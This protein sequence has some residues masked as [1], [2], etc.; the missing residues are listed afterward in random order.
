MRLRLAAAVLAGAVAVA[1]PP[2][3]GQA[4]LERGETVPLPQQPATVW[5]LNV[6]ALAGLRPDYEG[7]DDYSFLGAP[8][9][10]LRYGGDRFFVS[11]RDGIGATL[12]R[13][14]RFTAGPVLRYRFGRDQD[15]N[16]ALRGMGDVG[17]T[18]EAGAFMRFQEG[19][20]VVVINAA[21]GLNGGGHRGATVF[22]SL[23]YGGRLAER[24]RFS[25]GPSVTWASDNYMQSF[26]GVTPTQGAR[27]GY[28]PY[29]PGAGFKDV[30]FGGTLTWLATDQ[31]ALTAIAEV[32]ELLNDAADSP[33]VERAGNS[34][35]GFFGLALSYRFSW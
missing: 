14:G 9:V 2:A 22:A 27:A 11:S 25:L 24:W 26:F 29:S 35:Q 12:V 33:L 5:S 17:G 8:L 28:A 13:I 34:T 18:V 31:I 15:D 4:V 20:W 10:E 3:L 16:D 6:G 32:K 1:P 21:Q 7:S 19:G 30:G 23:G